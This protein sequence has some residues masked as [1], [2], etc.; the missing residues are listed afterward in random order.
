MPRV[1]GSMLLRLFVSD[2]NSVDLFRLNNRVPAHHRLRH[3]QPFHLHA[4]LQFHLSRALR[5]EVKEVAGIQNSAVDLA[6]Q[7]I[8]QPHDRAGKTTTSVFIATLC[9]MA[10]HAEQSD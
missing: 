4:R 6:V 3:A 7:R 10:I 5:L 9:Q 8:I 2:D 1:L